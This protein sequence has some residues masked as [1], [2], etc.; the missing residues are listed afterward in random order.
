M[1][2]LTLTSLGQHLK[3]QVSGTKFSDEDIEKLTHR[4]QFG[5][6]EVVKAK[7][8]EVSS[9]ECVCVTVMEEKSVWTTVILILQ[10]VVE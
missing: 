5:G 6:D 2:R 8:G 9:T 7:D 4:I 1:N 10:V 3:Q